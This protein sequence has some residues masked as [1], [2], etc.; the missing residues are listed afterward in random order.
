VLEDGIN[1]WYNAIL[2]PKKPSD[3]ESA[4]MVELYNLR[5]A[6]S[7]YFLGLSTELDPEVFKT[8]KPKKAIAVKP[9]KKAVEE[10]EE[11]C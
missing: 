9:K 4:E 11:G 7:N 1:G 2:L 5:K 3:L 8:Y 6:M 10:E